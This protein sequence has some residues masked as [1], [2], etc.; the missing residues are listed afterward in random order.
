MRRF[1]ILI[2]ALALPMSQLAAGSG[3]VIPKGKISSLISEYGSCEGVEVVNIGSIALG[4]LRSLVRISEADD[5]D[6]REA[7]QMVRG[8]KKL[9]IFDYEDC[10]EQ[11]KSQI[12]RKLNRILSDCE[13][14][15]EAS[16]AGER[17]SIYGSLDEKSELIRD[18]VIYTP[19]DCALICLFGNFSMDSIAKIVSND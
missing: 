12:T 19:A 14:L 3:K 18:C 11:Q 1:I 10:T 5:R 15:M 13:V 16:D 17:V 2:I 4:A 7:L 8:L 9:S 6:T